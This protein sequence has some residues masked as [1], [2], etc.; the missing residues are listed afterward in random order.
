MVYNDPVRSSEIR[1]GV[2]SPGFV[3]SAAECPRALPA[4]A[5]ETSSIVAH[6]NRAVFST[7]P[8]RRIVLFI[9]GLSFTALLVDQ[10]AA[11]P[12]RSAAAHNGS[13]RC[14]ANLQACE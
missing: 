14:V 12:P 8:L 5:H 3:S 1:G 6:K 9:S 11:M 10:S 13:G 2:G 7:R 4:A